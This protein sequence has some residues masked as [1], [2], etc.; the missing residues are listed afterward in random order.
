MTFHKLMCFFLPSLSVGRSCMSTCE[1]LLLLFLSAKDV[2]RQSGE[3]KLTQMID[4]HC[5]GQIEFKLKLEMCKTHKTG[6]AG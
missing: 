2:N 6:Y 5:E 3:K 4:T 1:L